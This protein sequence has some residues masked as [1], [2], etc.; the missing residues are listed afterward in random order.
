MS[1]RVSVAWDEGG[2]SFHLYEELMD[3]R[4]WLEVE[5]LE[6]EVARVENQ[7]SAVIRFPLPAKFV[8]EVFFEFHAGVLVEAGGGSWAFGCG[9]VGHGAFSDFVLQA[10]DVL[11]DFC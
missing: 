10:S 11:T 3:G 9:W 5:V 1:T 2:N 6:F 8:E 4:L 7:G